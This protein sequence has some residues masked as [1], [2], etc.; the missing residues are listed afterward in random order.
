MM[1]DLHAAV[2][3]YLDMRRA[4]GTQ[5][6]W[7]ESLLHQFVAFLLAQGADV[8][9]TA[10]PCTGRCSA[11]G[12]NRLPMRAGSPSCA[13]SP[14][15]FRRRNHAPRSHHHDCYPHLTAD[16]RLTFT[17]TMRLWR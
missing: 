8:V 4:L 9:T 3:E 6:K 7:P 15:G 2:G 12:C 11:L 14:A 13:P 5:L 1:T 16:R 17:A 10:L